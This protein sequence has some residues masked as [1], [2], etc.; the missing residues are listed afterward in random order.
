MAARVMRQKGPGDADRILPQRNAPVRHSKRG[1][2]KALY[3]S[4]RVRLATTR[5]ALVRSP[6]EWLVATM[7]S[8]D[9]PAA[10]AHPEWWMERLR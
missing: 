6:I 4:S 1:R 9:F 3:S 5:T 10:T 7:R 2:R 8:L